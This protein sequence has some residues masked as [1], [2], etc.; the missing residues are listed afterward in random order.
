MD[1]YCLCDKLDAELKG[2]RGVINN[3]VDISECRKL[4]GQIRQILP[5][6]TRDANDI[7]NTRNAILVNADSVAKN[8]LKEAEERALQLV[9]DSEIKRRAEREGENMLDDAYRQCDAL[10]LKTKEHLDE[11]LKETE[12]FFRTALETVST[13]RRE[14][15]NMIINSGRKSN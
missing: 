11:M 8:V 13:N 9:S 7:V 6:Y 3:Q 15:K 12:N 5:E 4:I 2:R 1:I 10:V 14:L